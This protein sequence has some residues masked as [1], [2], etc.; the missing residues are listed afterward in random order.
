MG[1]TPTELKIGLEVWLTEITDSLHIPIKITYYDDPKK[2]ADA[3]TNGKIT[4]A[5]APPYIFVRYFDE[6]LM[7]PGVVA[8]KGSREKASQLL[9]LVHKEDRTKPFRFFFA[10]SISIPEAKDD[11]KLFIKEQSIKTDCSVPAEIIETKNSQRAIFNLFFKKS[12]AAL[13]T[14]A[15]F[16]TACELNPQIKEK[17]VVYKQM[18]LMTDYLL[19]VRRGIKK[20]LYDNIIKSAFDVSK[21]VRG[22]QLLMLLQTDTVDYCTK[23]DLEPSRKLYEEWKQIKS[24][25]EHHAS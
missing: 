19:F 17:L 15:D 10:K 24:K 20:E 1:M 4:L 21:T 3:F 25:K 6:K 16:E 18:K 13:V 14:A 8:Y 11:A 2:M 7:L 22:R 5:V 9:M 12:S 23:E